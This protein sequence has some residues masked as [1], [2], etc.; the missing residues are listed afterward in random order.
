MYVSAIGSTNK[1]TS[2]VHKKYKN[3][4]KLYS[5]LMYFTISMYIIIFSLS[6]GFL[7]IYYY[8]HTNIS[9]IYFTPHM[10]FLPSYGTRVIFIF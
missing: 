5:L 3:K 6:L 7:Y 8:I 2:S 9:F 1:T 10:R 4:F